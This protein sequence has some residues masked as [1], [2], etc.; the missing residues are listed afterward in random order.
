M[1]DYLREDLHALATENL[2]AVSLT[3]LHRERQQ[4]ISYA[5]LEEN[6]RDELQAYTDTDT[7]SRTKMGEKN[8]QVGQDIVEEGSSNVS[9]T[10]GP[11]ECQHLGRIPHIHASETRNWNQS[12]LTNTERQDQIEVRM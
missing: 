5:N 10:P 2:K 11:G 7:P 1:E 12:H 4:I 8:I 6:I 3:R 9:G